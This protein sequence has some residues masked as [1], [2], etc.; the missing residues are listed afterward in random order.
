MTS[1]KYIAGLVA[2][3][4]TNFSGSQRQT[5]GRSVQGELERALEKVLKH[6]APVILAGRTDAGVHATGQCFR[7]TTTNS[8]PVERV[9]LALNRELARDVRVRQTRPVDEQFHPRFSARSR[10]YKYWI[11]DAAIPNPMLRTV[12]GQIRERLDARAMNEAAKVLWGRKDFVAWQSAGSP[13]KTTVREIKRLEVRRRRDV[14]GSSL[15]EVTIEAD[16]FLYQMVRNIV[17]A[18]IC[19]GKAELTANDLE[20]LTEGRDR[21]QC[22]PPAPPQGLSLIQV[23]YENGDH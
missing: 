17:G 15:V 14:Y 23:K 20:R 8:I 16:A 12:A 1:L 6:E 11:E 19:V 2:Y 18:L 5:N 7:F 21:T 9:S 10:T 4:G 3:D 13:T 22:P